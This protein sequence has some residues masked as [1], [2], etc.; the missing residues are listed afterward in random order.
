LSGIIIINLIINYKNFQ[1]VGRKNWRVN[2][3]R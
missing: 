1:W 2:E 3:S